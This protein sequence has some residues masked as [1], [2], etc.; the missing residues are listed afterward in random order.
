MWTAAKTRGLQQTQRRGICTMS[1]ATKLTAATFALL[2]NAG[3]V[4]AEKCASNL[5]TTTIDAP[6]LINCLRELESEINR[7]RSGTS[8]PTGAVIAFWTEPE[9]GQMKACP[10]GWS[11]LRESVGRTVVGAGKTDA[12]WQQY[13]DGSDKPNGTLLPFTEKKPTEVGGEVF[14]LLT[15]HEMPKH[16]HVYVNSEPGA[17]INSKGVP[18]PAFKFGGDAGLSPHDKATTE[19]GGNAVQNNMPP[20]IALYYCKKD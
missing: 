3:P 19:I 14:H 11:F 1:K 9:A 5:D 18:H 6:I 7:I 8:I 10:V 12:T 4:L 13:I 20:Y 16:S 15:I 2:I 17:H